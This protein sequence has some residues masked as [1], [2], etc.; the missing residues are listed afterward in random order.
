[1]LNKPHLHHQFPLFASLQRQGGFVYMAPSNAPSATPP[2]AP[3]AAPPA[4]PKQPTT[5]EAADILTKDTK[6]KGVKAIDAARAIFKGLGREIAKDSKKPEDQI[7]LDALKNILINHKT[8]FDKPDL[9]LSPE[10][11]AQIETGAV[12]LNPKQKEFILAKLFP[13]RIE[14][15]DPKE[16]TVLTK[17]INDSKFGTPDVVK[18]IFA[19]PKHPLLTFIS[20]TCEIKEDKDRQL[21]VNGKVVSKY[22]DL[23]ANLPDELKIQLSAIERGVTPPAKLDDLLA[24]FKT[25]ATDHNKALDTLQ[26][27]RDGLAGAGAA[28]KGGLLKNIPMI[29]RFFGAIMQAFKTGDWDTLGEYMTAWNASG[30][31]MKKFAE[32]I[33]SAKKKYADALETKTP[34]PSIS[35]LLKAYLNPRGKDGDALFCSGMAQRIIQEKGLNLFRKEAAP[36]IS[37]YLVKNMKLD[38]IASI[39]QQPDCVRVTAYKG[40]VKVALEFIS[41][42]AKPQMRVRKFS[43][44]AKNQETIGP[45][46]PL[47][48]ADW[49]TEGVVNS[50][51]AAPAATPKQ[52]VETKEQ[53]EA[54]EKENYKKALEKMV[55]KKYEG[56]NKFS[57]I[58]Q[59]LSTRFQ[60]LWPNKEIDLQE[61]NKGNNNLKKTDKNIHEHD[62]G[63]QEELDKARIDFIMQNFAQFKDILLANGQFRNFLGATG[64]SDESPPFRPQPPQKKVA[65]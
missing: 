4:A 32:S 59:I 58:G 43:M 56:D 57:L 29:L 64:A 23:I 45:A 13:Q 41:L 30:N 51:P 55:E 40:G 25:S 9:K 49:S 53:K 18:K 20:R 37:D 31:N 48:P 5:Q 22:V 52:N 10:Q 16:K 62:K 11:M 36:A 42:D 27:L 34:K 28:E 46:G 44:D 8:D 19:D 65:K 14:K 26:A 17:F 12:D 24:K 15:E 61:L 47:T 33:D 39:S 3:P 7:A 60:Q 38:S 54:K 1:M 63:K 35:L 6:G 21:T 50:A 2:V